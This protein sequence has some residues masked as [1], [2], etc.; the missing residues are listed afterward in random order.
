MNRLTIRWLLLALALLVGTGSAWAA[1]PTPM[2]R[3]AALQA[4]ASGQPALR[5][6]AVLRLSQVGRMEDTHALVDRLR[7]DDPTV[8]D[9]AGM[10]LWS[11]WGRSGDP[12]VDRLY[13][14]GVR[15]ME[16]GDWSQ[17]L[18]TFG[19]IIRRKPA[20]AEGWNKRATILFMMGELEASLKDCDEVIRRNPQHFGV[21][22]GFGQIHM[23]LGNLEQA[24]GYFERALEVNPNLDSIAAIVPVLRQSLAG[25]AGSRT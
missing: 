5:M 15:Q 1:G 14:V 3:A 2:N 6:A 21:L 8:R 4:L 13:Q 7:D 17:A 20:F 11:V 16:A 9:A 22:S 10:A 18:D 24:L 23:Q 12:A 25:R 19:K